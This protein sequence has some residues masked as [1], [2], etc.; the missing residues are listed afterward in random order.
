MRKESDGW[1][2]MFQLIHEIFKDRL[3][4]YHSIVNRLINRTSFILLILTF[5]Y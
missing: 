3:N 4:C 5:S 1:K 2:N